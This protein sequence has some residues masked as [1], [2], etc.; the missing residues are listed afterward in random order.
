MRGASRRGD[1]T[2]ERQAAAERDVTGSDRRAKPRRLLAPAPS[3]AT[4][5]VIYLHSWLQLVQPKW[6]PKN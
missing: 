4:Y 6:V 2:A 3:Q 5:L 1:P